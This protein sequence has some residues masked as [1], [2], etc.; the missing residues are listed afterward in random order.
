MGLRF[1]AR[2]IL[3]VFVLSCALVASPSAQASSDSDEFSKV[4]S[5][6]E[7]MSLS[8]KNRSIY[9]H[10]L[11]EAIIE[12][13]NNQRANYGSESR[14]TSARILLLK[15][16]IAEAEAATSG[17]SITVRLPEAKPFDYSHISKNCGDHIIASSNIQ[18]GLRAHH[19]NYYCLPKGQAAAQCPKGYKN[20]GHGYGQQICLAP[21]AE[22]IK[23][24]RHER[25]LDTKTAQARA[26][27]P[28]KFVVNQKPK[29]KHEVASRKG[30]L[31]NSSHPAYGLK[32]KS[33]GNSDGTEDSS[34]DTAP[35]GVERDVAQTDDVTAT[36]TDSVAGS[37]ANANFGT[38]DG[39]TELQHE[40]SIKVSVSLNATPTADP[41]AD[42]KATDETCPP[43]PEKVDPE[44]CNATT[45]AAARN[46]YRADKGAPHCLYAGNL[47]HFRDGIKKPGNCIPPTEFSFGNVTYRDSHGA[48]LVQRPADFT[49]APDQVICSP[50]VFNLDENGEP[51]HVP[52]G[53]DATAACDKAARD[54]EGGI[55]AIA[56]FRRLKDESGLN[57]AWNDF[58]YNI[59]EMCFPDVSNGHPAAS[60]VYCHECQ[61]L[62][63]R[64]YKVHRLVTMRDEKKHFMC[65]KLK[66]LDS[67]MKP[68]AAS[69]PSSK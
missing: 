50:Y 4:I 17:S 35:V 27:P 64:L 20:I 52:R 10:H 19:G 69:A 14:K 57:N 31:S 42:T 15:S 5:Y 8:E 32:N 41:D 28:T 6:N 7:L 36:A 56:F 29:P 23:Q 26:K 44:T 11:R 33:H 58:A 53:G 40:R 63:S 38:P 30:S 25:G 66:Q 24:V 60:V 21:S 16:L 48:K 34:L 67:S 9:L 65:G 3:L 55:G 39:E 47:S 13:E 45:I 2:F 49:C 46:Q 43:P 62:K 59:N 51:F 1:I 37:A 68:A 54:S 22:F 61:I 18:N 12:F